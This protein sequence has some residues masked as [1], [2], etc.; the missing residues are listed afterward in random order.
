[1]R[2]IKSINDCETQEEVKNLLN[3]RYN[4][5]YEK[6]SNREKRLEY[7]KEYYRKRKLEK[8]KFSK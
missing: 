4:R 6:P 1:M 8:I 2:E 3:D 7:Y 5:W